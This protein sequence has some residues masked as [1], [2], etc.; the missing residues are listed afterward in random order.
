[1]NATTLCDLPPV[2]SS[3]DVLLYVLCTLLV[4]LKVLVAG[5]YA[6]TRRDRSLSNRDNIENREEEERL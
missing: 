6:K 5:V 4:A 2:N 3:S 1:M